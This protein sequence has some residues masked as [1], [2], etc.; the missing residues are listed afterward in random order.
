MVII[1]ICPSKGPSTATERASSGMS[2]EQ[3]QYA[4]QLSSGIVFIALISKHLP[5]HFDDVQHFPQTS[6]HSYR[7]FGQYKATGHWQGGTRLHALM[8]ISSL[9]CIGGMFPFKAAR[10][11]HDLD[12]SARSMYV[13]LVAYRMVMRKWLNGLVPKLPFIWKHD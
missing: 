9:A 5:P 8:S 11:D 7:R 10:M 13:R 2:N 1:N 3:R 6:P 4:N 12:R